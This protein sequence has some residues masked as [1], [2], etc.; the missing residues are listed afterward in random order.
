MTYRVVIEYDD[1]FDVRNPECHPDIIKD[2]EAGRI[3]AYGV[4]LEALTSCGH[5]G[6][7]RWDEVDSIW[8]TLLN[9]PSWAG[10]YSLEQMD[11]RS[12]GPDA[13]H[14]NELLNQMLGGN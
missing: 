12:P 3:T 6:T 4:I 9:S 14:I 8:G 11:L 10:V 2:Y 13:N 7:T 5:C 1:E